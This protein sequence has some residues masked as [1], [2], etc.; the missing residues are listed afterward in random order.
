[1]AQD[2]PLGEMAL[3][4]PPL[5][6]LEQPPSQPLVLGVLAS[7]S[8]TNFGA[9]LRAIEAGE[10][11]ARVA[12]LIYNNPEAIVSARA[13]EAGIPTALLNHRD[14]ASRE[15]LDGAIVATLQAY[16][17]SHV[18]MAG[19]MRIV[20]PVLIAAYPH[21]MI[22]IHPSLLPAFK[23]IRAIEQALAAQV[24]LT[25]CTVHLVE[26][27]VDSGPILMQAAVPILPG[28][29]V[30]SLHARIQRQEHRILPAALQRLALGLS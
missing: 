17:V 15:D 3:V 28:D 24:K 25:G 8:G 1:M 19:W 21:R 13:M 22:N 18:V 29:T 20:T 4:S 9:I 10:L 6:S 2:L 11:S 27:R 23:G 14:F 16:G 26:E 7:G 30:D 12:V 5:P